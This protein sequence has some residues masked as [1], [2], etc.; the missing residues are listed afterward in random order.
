MV[1]GFETPDAG[2]VLLEGNDVTHVP[3][4]RRDVNQVFQSYALFPH[5]SVRDNIAFG[6]RMQKLPRPEI[7]QRVEQI[8]QL[9]SLTGMEDRKPSQLSG[10]QQQRVALARAIVCQP[11]VLLLDEPLSA[12][13]AKL[14]EAMQL[15]LRSLHQKLGMTFIFVTHD[16]SEALTMSDRI[17]VMNKGKIEQIGA[18]MDVY[19]RPA[20]TF[21][22]TFVGQ[23]NVWSG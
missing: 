19:L 12:L 15:E 2:T 21:V 3:P 14:R 22:A 13:D 10:G 18:P 20:T 7:A 8:M 17:A 6:L 5:L 16:Q 23:A 4:H 1:A 11:K 9:V